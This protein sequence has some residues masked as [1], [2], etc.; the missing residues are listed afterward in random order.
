MDIY[1]DENWMFWKF[2]KVGNGKWIDDDCK[3]EY[4]NWFE[5]QIQI[6]SPDDWYNVKAEDFINHSGVS[7]LYS[8][9]GGSPQKVAQ[10]FHPNHEWLPWKFQTSGQGYW[11]NRLNVE[12]YLYWLGDKLEIISPNDW[13][14]VT[15]DDFKENDGGGIMSAIGGH[16]KLIME[17][18]VNPQ[19][20]KPWLFLTAPMGFWKNRDNQ[21]EYMNWLERE[22]GLL[23]L[24][25]WYDL[26]RDVL[27]RRNGSGLLSHYSTSLQYILLEL[28][29]NHEWDLNKLYKV[30]KNQAQLFNIV[31]KLFPNDEIKSNFRGHKK[32]RFEGSRMPMELDIWVSSKKLAFE[33]QGE[34]HFEAFHRGITQGSSSPRY[35]L[36]SQ[37]K[38]DQEKRKACKDNEICLVEIDYKWERTEEFVAQKIID[39]GFKG[40]CSNPCIQN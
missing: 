11:N 24:D 39:A 6:K 29:P 20:W 16:L 32:L 33:Y 10:F 13:Y 1:P 17:H 23:S 14:E 36:K 37:Q 21:L 28:Y 3:K 25:D 9:F 34:Q 31:K 30:G 8:K 22:L 15:S 40:L 4:L 7:L 26:D 35:S 27:K 12:K 38:R 5:E 18:I 2:D 19:G